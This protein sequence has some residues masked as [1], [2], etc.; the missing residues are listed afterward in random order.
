MTW[1]YTSTDLTADRDKVRTYVGDT[2][3]TDP[4]LSDEQIALAITEE[5][6]ARAASALA[7]DWI[8]ATFARQADKRAG[9]LSISYSQKSER[10]VEMA[11]TLRRESA[12]LVLPYCGGISES[13]KTTREEDTDRVKPA[14]SVAMMDDPTLAAVDDE[15]DA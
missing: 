1:T 8:A 12:K 11:R 7:C 13:A 10:Y 15:G 9:D 14:F 2:D 4:L 3:S 5:G 6:T